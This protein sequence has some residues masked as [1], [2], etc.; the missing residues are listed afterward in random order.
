MKGKLA[1][2][3]LIFILLL[4][5]QLNAQWTSSTGLDGMEVYDIEIFDST[6]FLSGGSDGVYSKPVNNDSWIKLDG[7]YGIFNI[8]STDSVLFAQG[9]TSG[10]CLFR[11]FDD[12]DS[13]E[14]LD[15]FTYYDIENLSTIKN[16]IIISKDDSL[17]LSNDNG[18]SWAGIGGEMPVIENNYSLTFDTIIFRGGGSIDSILRSDNL[19]QSWSPITRLG[20]PN[21]YGKKLNS[22]VEFNDSLWAATKK[23]VF[24]FG[25]NDVGWLSRNDGISIQ[26][27]TDL[28]IH[29]DTLHCSTKTGIY[30]LDQGVW[31]SENGGL[32]ILDVDCLELYDGIEFCGTSCGPFQRQGEED[33]QAIYHG[34]NHLN[35]DFIVNNGHDIWVCTIKG[36]FKSTNRGV[37]F[38]YIDNEEFSSSRQMV[39]T[40]SL[41]YIS[42][43]TGLFI[44]RDSGNSWINISD[45]L[46]IRGE[47][48]VGENYIFLKSVKTYRADHINYNWELLPNEIADANIWELVAMDSMV[49]VSVYGSG[50]Y[51]SVDNGDSFVYSFSESNE[52][53]CQDDSFYAINPYHQLKISEDGLNW[54]DFPFSDNE[55]YASSIAVNQEVIIVGG[56]LLGIT[57][58][59]LMLGIS[60]DDGYT[61][62]DVSDGLPVPSWPIINHI[63]IFDNRI[64]ASPA[65]NGLW[66]RDDLLVGENELNGVEPGDILLYPN[67]V[68]G[69]LTIDL[70]NSFIEA[71]HLKICDINGRIVMQQKLPTLKSSFELADLKPGIYFLQFV[72]EGKTITQKIIKY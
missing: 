4:S 7:L 48:T 6:I 34:L 65:H 70:S 26:R 62:S 22:I 12:G 21:Y 72:G 15:L 20:L 35:I 24:V 43:N 68:K 13:W 8:E 50:T 16:N 38:E 31:Y 58:Y 63:G 10:V 3:I 9:I 47:F 19:G 14:E 1:F 44:S 2:P 23:G 59:D 51:L 52:I 57:L 33:W 46:Y 36:L 60:Y 29:N 49:L 67:P 27:I 64:F 41:F 18:E 39:I 25:G 54:S 66:Y 37:D 5:P 61:W 28:M 40:D 32:E 55:W 69:L 30:Y 53:I 45:S 17:L 11:S 42:T 71:V 56:S